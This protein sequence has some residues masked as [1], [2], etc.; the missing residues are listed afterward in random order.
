MRLAER[1]GLAP[2]AVIA[3]AALAGVLLLAAAVTALTPS[4]DAASRAAAVLDAKQA[5]GG[6]KH[7]Q[8]ADCDE[9][10]SDLDKAEDVLNNLDDIIAK[11]DTQKVYCVQIN[12]KEFGSL[13]EAGLDPDDFPLDGIRI[14]GKGVD[15]LKIGGIDLDK[16]IDRAKDGK[17]SDHS[18]KDSE[19]DDED[20]DSGN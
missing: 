8:N 1:N 20:D 13:E 19:K 11:G 5:K 18:D 2:R 17:H 6:G 7:H 12:D 16:L 3:G 14:S 9:K 10:I 4:G 15:G